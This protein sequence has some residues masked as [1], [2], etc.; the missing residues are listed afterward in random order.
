MSLNLQENWQQ[1]YKNWL[2]RFW[3]ITV[4]V[5]LPL[6]GSRIDEQHKNE[7]NSRSAGSI[8]MKL[9]FI[10]MFSRLGFL[11]MQFEFM[12]LPPILLAQ[13]GRDAENIFFLL[14]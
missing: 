7:Y 10:Y 13:F 5:F 1:F 12:F 3:I 11:N 4:L 14:V 6:D 2:S 8:L 9:M